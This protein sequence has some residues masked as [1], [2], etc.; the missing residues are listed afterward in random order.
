VETDLL[1]V[2]KE[3]ILNPSSRPERE[4]DNDEFLTLKETN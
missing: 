2:L 4:V 1:H 3:E